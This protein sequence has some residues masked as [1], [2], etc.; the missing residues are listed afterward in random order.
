MFDRLE[1]QGLV[2]D[3]TTLSEKGKRFNLRASRA[4]LEEEKAEHWKHLELQRKKK[5]AKEARY[6]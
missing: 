4:Q 5:F 2:D 3:K 1:V 6:V